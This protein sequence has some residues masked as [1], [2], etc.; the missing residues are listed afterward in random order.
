MA[1]RWC[2]KTKAFFNQ[3]VPPGS[4]FLRVTICCIAYNSKFDEKQTTAYT[5]QPAYY[6]GVFS[7]KT[8]TISMDESLNL[9]LVKATV[10]L[11]A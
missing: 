10:V 1:T 5:K 11:T 9:L 7:H 4:S 3:L 2:Q 8:N 6:S